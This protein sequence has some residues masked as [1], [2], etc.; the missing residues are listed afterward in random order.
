M[1]TA[2]ERGTKEDVEP[3]SKGYVEDGGY[4][5]RRAGMERRREA[6]E[7]LRDMCVEHVLRGFSCDCVLERKVSVKG[8]VQ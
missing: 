5:R 6:Q 2:E 7:S 8:K 3:I 1:K 4:Y